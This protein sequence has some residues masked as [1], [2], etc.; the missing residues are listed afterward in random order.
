VIRLYAFLGNPGREYAL[1]RHN[2]AWRLAESLSFA[3]RL[4]WQAKFKGS[5]ASLELGAE[6]IHLVLPGTYMNNSGESVAAAAKFFK[7]PPGEV[8]VCHDELE[9]PFGT[10]GFKFGGG[11]GGHNGLRSLKAHLGT[12]DFY[13]FRIG[14]GRPNHD[15]ISGWVLSDLPRP[16]EEFLSM[17]ILPEAARMLE[18]CMAG[19]PEA[20]KDYFVKVRIE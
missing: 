3:G 8:L 2:V 10:V 20:V 1:N 5:Y 18:A 17:K 11:L 6:R 12:P 9:I 7:V 14:I 15:D 13:R 4:S 19:G 16:E